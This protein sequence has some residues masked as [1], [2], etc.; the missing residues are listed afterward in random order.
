MKYSPLLCKERLKLLPLSACSCYWSSS[1]ELYSVS[2]YCL[3]EFGCSCDVLP[4]EGSPSA[5]EV[6]PDLTA[7]FQHA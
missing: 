6:I 7:K 1:Q 4:A 5:A 2:A 3:R